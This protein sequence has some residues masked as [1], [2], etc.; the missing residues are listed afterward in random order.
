M[1]IVYARIN[2]DT[3]KFIR[4]HCQ[5]S[6][7]Y[8]ARK[9]GFDKVKIESWENKELDICPT[10]KQAKKK[11]GCSDELSK[12]GAGNCKKDQRKGN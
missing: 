4:N 11:G 8:I 10:I 5:V 1:K 7:E 9:T 6:F 12:M 2:K 3:L